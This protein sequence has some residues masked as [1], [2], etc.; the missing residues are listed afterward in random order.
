VTRSASSFRLRTLLA[1]GAMALVTTFLATPAL[2]LVLG[3]RGFEL[4][5]R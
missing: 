4:A 1:Y 5:A 2:D 3:K